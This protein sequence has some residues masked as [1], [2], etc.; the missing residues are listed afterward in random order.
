MCT[1]LYGCVL[2]Q[3]KEEKRHGMRE[4]PEYKCPVCGGE[5]KKLVTKDYTG[6]SLKCWD[7]NNHEQIGYR[8]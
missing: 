1:Y 4:N 8:S 7:G 5:L 6:F 3:H 2:C